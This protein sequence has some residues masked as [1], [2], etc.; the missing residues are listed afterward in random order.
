VCKKTSKKEV[1]VVS[2]QRRRP[3]SS[4]LTIRSAPKSETEEL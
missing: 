4:R 2:Q 3:R 1:K